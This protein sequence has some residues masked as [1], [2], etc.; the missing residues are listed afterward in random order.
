MLAFRSCQALPLLRTACE[1]GK[2]KVVWLSR[3]YLSEKAACD[4][5][6]RPNEPT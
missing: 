2:A 5:V 1:A 4:P 3:P 6:N